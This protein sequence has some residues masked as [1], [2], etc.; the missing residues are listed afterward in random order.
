MPRVIL[1]ELVAVTAGRAPDELVFS[2]PLGEP[3]RIGNWR[4]RVWEPAIRA[5]AQEGLRP[6][7]CGIRQRHWPSRPGRR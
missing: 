4:R 3:L 2:S 5:V 6:M 1:D 7:T